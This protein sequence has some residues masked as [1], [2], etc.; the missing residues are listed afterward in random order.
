MNPV[1]AITYRYGITQ[2]VAALACLMHA[3]KSGTYE[4]ISP[5]EAAENFEKL[6]L[7]TRNQFVI[8]AVMQCG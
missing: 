2:R 4:S 8:E 6:D 5:I 1:H 7:Q 3:K